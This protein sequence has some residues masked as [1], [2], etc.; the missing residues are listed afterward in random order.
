M[1]RF[2]FLL[3]LFIRI[4]SIKLKKYNQKLAIEQGRDLY[5]EIIEDKNGTLSTQEILSNPIL[6]KYEKNYEEQLGKKSDFEY[7]GEKMK[8]VGEF[9][10]IRIDTPERKELRKQISKKLSGIGSF[11]GF[12]E[13][14]EE[15]HTG[16]VDK[17]YE[18]IIVIGAPASG[19]STSIVNP[20]SH[21]LNARI[22]DSDEVK[23]LLPEYNNGI[24][25]GIVHKESSDIILIEMILPKFYEGGENNGDNIIIPIV[26]KS[27]K[28]VYN[29]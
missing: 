25:A 27:S 8:N 17:D 29:L 6:D 13:N 19:K 22:I 28:N 12:N 18:A 4:N 15:K 9:Q 2:L 7:H 23:K 16:P 5:N 26:G 20:I 3:F 24:G 1:N 10:T 11:E 21:Q 14:D